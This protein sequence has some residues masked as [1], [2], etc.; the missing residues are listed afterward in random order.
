MVLSSFLSPLGLGL[1]EFGSTVQRQSLLDT[2]M[3][4]PIQEQSTEWK[5]EVGKAI[6]P[7]Q[8][9]MGCM[10]IRLWVFLFADGSPSQR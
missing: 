4:L 7:V 3:W 10:L 1:L 6:C 8:P 2:G 5:K 9:V